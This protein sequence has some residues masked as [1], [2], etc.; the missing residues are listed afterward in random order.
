MLAIRRSAI[1]I[2]VIVSDYLMV[3]RWHSFRFLTLSRCLRRARQRTSLRRLFDP[4]RH[5]AIR[6]WSAATIASSVLRRPTKLPS[7]SAMREATPMYRPTA[8]PV[9]GSSSL[10]TC[11]PRLTYTPLD[12]RVIVSVLSSFGSGSLRFGSMTRM[13]SPRTFTAHLPRRLVIMEGV[14]SATSMVLQ[15]RDARKLGYQGV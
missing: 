11:Y 10:S 8:R 12:L 7:E 13:G 6:C 4:L 15:R 1:A 5:L 9:F 14:G 2:Q 3:M